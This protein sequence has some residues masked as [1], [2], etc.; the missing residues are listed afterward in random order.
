LTASSLSPAPSSNAL[1]KI[2][3][4]LLSVT[5][6]TGLVDFARR[7]DARVVNKRQ[8]ENLACAGAFDGLNPHRAQVHTAVELL[9][10][11]AGSAA[12]ERESSQVNLFGEVAVE[13]M[14][15][16]VVADWDPNDR[17]KREFEAIGFYLSAHPLDDYAKALAR[18]GVVRQ[19]ELTSRAASSVE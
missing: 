15:L 2:G 8:L 12:A 10:R 1:K 14:P 5:D 18:L 17:L 3:R 13:D 6:K 16:P 4:A 9:I 19:S 7:L 11:H